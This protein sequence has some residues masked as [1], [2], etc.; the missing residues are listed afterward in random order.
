[1]KKNETEKALLPEVKNEQQLSGV[2]GSAKKPVANVS[3]K[4]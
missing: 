4:L 3:I 2:L 1:M